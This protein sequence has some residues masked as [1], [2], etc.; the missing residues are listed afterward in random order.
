MSKF[1]RNL[2]FLACLTAVFSGCRKKAFDDYYG[3][4][5]TLQPPIYQVLQARGNFTNLL[6]CI[7]KSGYT[8]TLSG[9]GYWTLF[10]PNDA[11]FATYFSSNATIKSMANMDSVT[12]RKIVT[13]CLV[14]NAFQTDHIADFQ[15]TTGWVT[16]TAFKRRTAY[17][18]GVYQ[19]TVN[20]VP[21][22]VIASNRNLG[23][24]FG[25]NNNKYV[26]Y[27][28]D[29]FL[30]TKGLT[31][32]D[33]NYFF[34]N[35]TYSGFNVVDGKVVTK[36]IIAENGIIHEI[37]KVLT[38]L[39]SLEQY[40]AANPQYSV[41]KSLYDK[42]MVTYTANSDATHRNTVLT[43]S[44]A[45]VY[46]KLYLN[47]LAYSPNNENYLKVQ[48]NDAQADGYS[49]FVPTNDVLTAYI[50]NVILGSGY[51]S[52]DV[53]PQ[54]I[55]VDLLNAHMW[56]TT[57]WPSKFASTNNFQGEPAR[58]SPTADVVDKKF[59]S[60]GMFYGTSKVQAANVFSSVFGKVYLDPNYSLMTR[61]LNISLRYTITNPNLKFTLILMPD[62]VLRSLGYDYSTAS[63]AF[64]YTSAG[65]TTIG[66]S[67]LTNLTRILNAHV[68]VT[69]QN[70][71]DNIAGTGVV[72]TF[73]G[74]YIKY[75]ANT[76]QAAGN[77]DA[78]QSLVVTGTKTANN[79]RVY[80]Q[81]TGLLQYSTV[82]IANEIAKQAVKTTDPFYDFYQY[83]TASTQYNA[84]AQEITG[85]ALGTF[86]TVFIPNHAAI[87]Q[88]VNDGFLP[89][90]A[91]V[92]NYKPT[93]AADQ[94][95]VNRFILAHIING[96]TIAPDGLKTGSF[97]TLLKN[98]NGDPVNM[99]LN[100]QANNLTISDNYSRVSTV[101]APFNVLANYTLIHQINGYLKYQY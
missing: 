19:E 83:L 28:T 13:Y 18:D 61:L 72:E 7:D 56:Q 88:A 98:G 51:A 15:S 42:Y 39:P 37:D 35:S 2:F 16:G 6:A 54:Q 60:N 22:S 101:V 74:D 34:P 94:A 91:G 44:N 26:P 32:S 66:G 93:A 23:Y 58:F 65:V 99:L 89:G 25:D 46:V 20:S 76:F 30:T 67:A 17:Y 40:L 62:A 8:A 45:T 12:A 24:I 50:N 100:N 69:A 84:T 80:Y 4:P 52:L 48:D 33:Y 97:A 10:A 59:C 63:S 68:V 29:L 1:L 3:R 27:I 96:T 47:L 71:L 64:T 21:T 41:F 95:L 78:S 86:Y 31:S 77:A 38:P 70:Q 36:N 9:A 14:Y 85:I 81:N 11:A 75:N 90:T 73:N 57:V 92:P 79:G 82:T 55:I 5:A 43:G 53:L 87:V 49:M